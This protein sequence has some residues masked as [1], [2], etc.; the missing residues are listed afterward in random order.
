MNRPMRIGLAL[1]TVVAVAIAGAGAWVKAEP[2]AIVDGQPVGVSAD[3]LVVDLNKGT[4]VMTGNVRVERG[5]LV[6]RCDRL[7]A[8]YDAAPHVTWAH[9][10]G[11]VVASWKGMQAKA[12]EAELHM[13][14][15]VLELRGGV[16][17]TRAGA[18]LEAASAQVDFGT[19]K[20]TLDK[21]SGSI[22]LPSS[23]P[24][25]P[26]RSVDGAL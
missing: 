9:A 22:P 3:Q 23:M 26:A 13:K 20:V 2:L 21:V 25:W 18:W 19:G 16:K 14:R 8:R 15:R 10:S 11:H 1:G 5:E 6:V 4:A 17:L 24:A 12:T 7:D